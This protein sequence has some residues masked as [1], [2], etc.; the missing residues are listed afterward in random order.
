MDSALQHRST[1]SNGGDNSV[2]IR[3]GRLQGIRE[4]TR[5]VL[6]CVFVMLD[7]VLVYYSSPE[8]GKWVD[9]IVAII[10]TT[11]LFVFSYSYRKCEPRT[12]SILK[13][14]HCC[15]V[16]RVTVKE[17][18]LILLQTIPNHINV[19]SLKQELLEAFPGIVNV[20]DLHVWHFAGD[21]I[22]STAHIIFRDPE[23]RNV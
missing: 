8:V 12:S 4:I 16:D 23:V 9:P 7:S 21:K 5:D 14:H 22:I 2:R 13:L 3:A 18:G 20:H 10:S 19:N 17:S 6:G 11:L 15:T 1:V